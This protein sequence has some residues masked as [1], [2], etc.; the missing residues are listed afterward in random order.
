MFHFH[1]TNEVQKSSLKS[2]RLIQIDY[3]KD[4]GDFVIIPECFRD[5]LNGFLD[6]DGTFKPLGNLIRLNDKYSFS[7]F[8]WKFE[9]KEKEAL[10]E[11]RICYFDA[12][13]YHKLYQL[14]PHGQIDTLRD[15]FENFISKRFDVAH[16]KKDVYFFVPYRITN[17]SIAGF[18]YSDFNINNHLKV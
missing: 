4:P 13:D 17:G 3:T 12:N 5:A 7:I 10:R 1:R 8:N 14:N 11:M 2:D 6:R 16:H 18:F 15:D 9:E